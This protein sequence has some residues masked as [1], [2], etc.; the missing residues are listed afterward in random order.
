MV[1]KGGNLNAML[2]W[3]KNKGDKIIN[4][5]CV[6][7]DFFV[8]MSRDKELALRACLLYTSDAA[9]E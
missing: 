1:A 6:H 8:S 5:L 3:Q 4:G 9:D 2:P 7:C